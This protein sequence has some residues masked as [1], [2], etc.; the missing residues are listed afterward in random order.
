MTRRI[1]VSAVI[2]FGLAWLSGSAVGQQISAKE[3]LIGAWSLVSIDFVRPDGSRSATF[4]SSPK[5][6]AFFCI[7]EEVPYARHEAA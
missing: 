6:I 5:G 1:N 4:G 2:I 3:Q 7:G